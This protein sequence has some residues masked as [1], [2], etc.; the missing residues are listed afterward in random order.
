MYDVKHLNNTCEIKEKN[1]IALGFFDGV[2]NGHH[3]VIANTI[4]DGYGSAVFTFPSK[5]D[6]RKILMPYEQKLDL[7]RQ[8][9]VKQIISPTSLA[10]RNLSGE[11][12]VNLLYRELNVR[13][14]SCGYDFVF[15]KNRSCN[16]NDLREICKKNNI[17]LD[18]V[19][20]VTIENI[21][22]STTKIKECI[23]NGNIVFANKLLGYNYFIE[24]TV[25]MGLQIGRTIERPTI[26]QHFLEN[27]IIPKFGAYATV[28][29]VD[30]K[31]LPSATN[32]GVK[33]TIVGEREPL[34]ET[35]ILN[36]DGDLYGQKIKVYF[37]E[38]IRGEKKFDSLEE[39]K[40]N[41][42]QIAG[43]SKNS[44]FSENLFTIKR[45]YDIIV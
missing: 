25:E 18:I 16:I 6:K 35:Y 19:E 24:A 43:Y 31:L 21:P 29:L 15:G 33:P 32:V 34:C 4:L 7:I 44:N 12:F 17:H 45:F 30:G 42:L 28:T 13:R 27:Q 10:F 41:I 8:T 26:N 22:V 39:L 38:Y 3:R 23:E 14:I 2:H 37:F 1:A 36:Y 40:D 9:G 20:P 11:E 5:M